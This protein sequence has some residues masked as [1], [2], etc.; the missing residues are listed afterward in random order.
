MER[1]STSDLGRYAVGVYTAALLA[2]C[3]GGS[4]TPLTPSFA[5]VA[6]ARTHAHR[7]YRALYSFEGGLAGDGNSPNAG[8]IYVDGSLYGT[9][10]G[11]GRNCNC[12]T[13]FSITPSGTEAVLHSFGASGDGKSPVASLLS[14]RGTLYGTTSEGGANGKGTVF[15]ITPSGTEAVLHSFGGPTDGKYPSAP[16]INVDGTLYGTTVEGGANGK[17]SVFSITPSGTEAVLYSF[18]G[19]G[20]G[21]FPHGGLIFQ[22]PTRNDNGTMYGTT[23]G[24][25]VNDG[26]TVF[27]I[28]PSGK[29]TVLYRFKPNSADGTGPFGGLI[30]VKGTLYGTTYYGGANG[31][32]YGTVFSVVPSS[33]KEAVLYSFGVRPSAENPMASLINVKGTL[34]GTSENG[35][36]HCYHCGTVFS[37]TTSGAQAVLHSF[38]HGPGGQYP[39]GALL[40]VNGTLYGTT[41]EG[42]EKDDGT[43]FSLS[44]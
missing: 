35:G 14:V 28:T 16:L 36:A 20:N 3:G 40:N 17:G 4:G 9:T 5:G 33:R 11:G 1:M 44:P 2:S 27:E 22:R 29:E 30:N 13:V 34:Y 10:G 31:C 43:V 21:A 24:G 19:K 37:I 38:Q 15:S 12:G 25:G 23:A 42:G 6:A 7:V 41:F 8:L 32:C 39:L 18:G 26:G